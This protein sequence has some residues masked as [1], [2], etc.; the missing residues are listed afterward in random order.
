KAWMID[1]QLGRRNLTPEQMS[2]YRGKQYDLRKQDKRRNLK[3]NTPKPQSEA[4]ENTAHDLAVQHKV[5]KATIERDAAYAKAIDLL[6]EKVGPET[7]QV[8]L[9]RETNVTQQDVK[10]LAK[11]AVQHAS[12]AKEALEAATHAKT[13]KQARQIVQHKVREVRDYQQYIDAIAR[14]NIP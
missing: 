8:L 4:S 13:P 5:S 12:T 9:A 7:R 11:M 3:Q 10:A 14:S 2:Y 1:H 6:A